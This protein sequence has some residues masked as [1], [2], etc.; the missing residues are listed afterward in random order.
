MSRHTDLI[1]ATL[2]SWLT[3][4]TAQQR[5]AYQA[6]LEQSLADNARARSIWQRLQAPDSFCEDELAQAVGSRFNLDVDARSSELIELRHAFNPNPNLVT[7]QKTEVVRRN[8]LAASMANFTVG[9][10]Q[11]LGV[12]S[13]LLPAGAFQ[14]RPGLA[15]HASYDATLRIPVVPEAWASMC[16]ELDLGTRY[17]QHIEQTLRPLP[18]SGVAEDGQQQWLAD[19]LMAV[20]RSDLAVQARVGLLREHLDEGASQM[21]LDTLHNGANAQWQGRPLAFSRLS[22]LTTWS[23]DG[24]R[25]W[26]MVVIEQQGVVDSPCVV[27][28]PGEPTHP[29]KQ[30]PSFAAFERA[31]REQ[32]RSLDYQRYFQAFV[33]QADRAAFMV[34]LQNTLSPLPLFSAIPTP[35]ADADIGL[36]KVPVSGALV[37]GLYD[38]LLE[39]IAADARALVAPTAE[40]DRLSAQAQ[41][42][43]EL[44]SALNLLNA[45]ALFVPGLDLLALGVGA[46]QLLRETFVGVDDWRH[47]Q[48]REALGHLFSVGENLALLG[49][50]VG[51]GVLASRSAFVERM[52]PI[53]DEGGHQRLWSRDARGPLADNHDTSDL[54]RRLGPPF[55]GFDSTTLEQVRLASGV[56]RAQLRLVHDDAL[57]VPPALLQAAR[58]SGSAIPQRLDALAA[59]IRRDFPGLALEAANALAANLNGRERYQLQTTARVPLRIAEQARVA[60]REAQLNRALAGLI[61]PTARS[62]DSERLSAALQ[63]HLGA[64][65]PRQLFE[66]AANDRALTARLLGQRR[67]WSGWHPPVRQPNGLFGYALSGRG[68]LAGDALLQRLAMLYPSLPEQTLANMREGLGPDP[69]RAVV[70][71]ERQLQLLRQSLDQWVNTPATYRDSE[72]NVVAVLQHDRQAVSDRLTA[73]WRLESPTAH[74]LLGLHQVPMVDLSEWQV[75][76]LPSLGISLEHVG[77]L[78]LES[79]GLEEDPSEFLRSFPGLEALEMSD[80]RLTAIPEAVADMPALVLLRMGSNRLQPSPDLFVPLFDLPRLQRLSLSGNPLQ[81]PPLAWNMLGTL[82]TLVDLHLNRMGLHVSPGALQQLGRLPNLQLLSMT[83]N[84]IVMSAASS[85]ALGSLNQLRVLNLSRNPLGQGLALQGLGQLEFI[86]LNGC[87]LQAWPDGL[88]ELMNRTPRQLVEVDLRNNPIGEVPVLAELA[89]FNPPAPYA[90]LR[91]SR[92]GLTP[93][94]LERLAQAGVESDG[95]SVDLEWTAGAPEPLSEA[96]AELR[97]M[98]AAQHFMLALDRSAEMASYQNHPAAGR[99]RLWAL[100]QAL[101]EPQ[102]ED[103]GVGL[104]HLRDQVFAIGEEV[105]MTCGDGI[106]LIVQRCETL[107][108]AYRASRAATAEEAVPG[109]LALGQQLLRASLIDEVAVAITQRRMDRRAA[110]FPEAEARGVTE[111]QVL[112]LTEQQLAAAP[113]LDPLDDLPTAGLARGPD[114][115]D[116]ILMLRMRLQQPLGLLEQPQA[117]LYP[118]PVSE[119]LLQRIAAWVSGEDTLVRRQAW[120]VEQPWWRDFLQRYQAQ[121]W[122][123]LSEHWNQGYSFIFERGRAEPEVVALPDDVRETISD[124]ADDPQLLHR[125]LSP[126][127]Q[128]L[129]RQRLDLAWARVQTEWVR[130]RTQEAFARLLHE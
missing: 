83:D 4:A 39:R 46:G 72:G 7:Q 52:S 91:I 31:L 120:L 62:L 106:Q 42:A 61:W 96:I 23:R 1:A 37:R 114:E 8:L 55:N 74:S 43:R 89:L 92:D 100:I 17:Q 102:P 113:A 90:P 3:R 108:H 80:N 21:L 128:E 50:N 33:G 19:S 130:A 68:A 13:V 122:Q 82:N 118:Q 20:L 22:G 124:V 121:P 47:G 41:H 112:S 93:Q 115:A 117:M 123:Q 44:A 94:S 75:G 6:S 116:F 53:M 119:L 2:P 84:Q 88:S 32:L 48:T 126:A 25:L 59:P 9:Q 14:P 40:L 10:A 78:M 58:D 87:G 57:P 64:Q 16:R 107:V 127:E 35:D 79:M 38:D 129:L 81:I 98:P 63:Q 12:G 45:A 105:M 76:A 125:R 34:R 15:P 110:L 66:A 28:S 5:R 30:Y 54:L 73:A 60:L 56:S 97:G 51:A 86:E 67:R 95:E 104:S 71:L 103:D 24:T 49:A 36:R 69:L 77:S 11:S 109:L 65:D 111:A 99:G 101:T 85:A 26:R 29:L 18:A 27:Y 70:D